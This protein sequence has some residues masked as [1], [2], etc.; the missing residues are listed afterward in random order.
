MARLD[1]AC[2]ISNIELLLKYA[3]ELADK[4]PCFMLGLSVGNDENIDAVLTEDASRG[5][6]LYVRPFANVQLLRKLSE[7][8][9]GSEMTVDEDS[10]IDSLSFLIDGEERLLDFT[11]PPIKHKVALSMVDDYVYGRINE[12]DLVLPIDP[13]SNLGQSLVAAAL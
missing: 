4:V 5:G 8:V 6:E 13:V 10:V 2:D 1:L 11:P 7:T 9:R 3:P 12:G